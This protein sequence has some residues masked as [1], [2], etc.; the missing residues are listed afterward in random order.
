MAYIWIN[1]VTERMYEPDVLNS[2]LEQHGYNRFRTSGDWLTIV[3]EKYRLMVEETG[4]LVVDVRCPKIKELLE[5]LDITSEIHIPE[6][7]PIL[8]HC[9]KEG[10][11]REDLQDDEKI[12]TTPCQALADMGNALALSKTWFITWNQFL[13]SLGS[14][15]IGTALNESPIPPGFFNEMGIKTVSITG[16][17]QIRAYFKQGIP[18]EVQLVEMLYCKDGCHNGDGIRACES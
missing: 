14:E 3:K 6:I 16:E 18:N 7:N 11:E 1:P 12:I 8:I 2:F 9:G 5:E 17:E 4:Q 10:S 13:K 15:P